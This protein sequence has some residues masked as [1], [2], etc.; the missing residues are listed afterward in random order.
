MMVFALL[1]I[2]KKVISLI[3]LIDASIRMKK[4][5]DLFKWFLM[6]IFMKCQVAH[7]TYEI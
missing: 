3:Q 2:T 1:F 4:L 7:R 5:D 6:G